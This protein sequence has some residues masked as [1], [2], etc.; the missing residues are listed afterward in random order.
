MCCAQEHISTNMEI[1]KGR[2]VF[3]LWM[4]DHSMMRGCVKL[5]DP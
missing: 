4:D 5:G 1:E 2:L 3:I